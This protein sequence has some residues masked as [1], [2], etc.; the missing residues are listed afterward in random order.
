MS[1]PAGCGAILVVGGYGVVGSQVCRLLRER[2][3]AAQ[4]LIGGRSPDKAAALAR[5]LDA[6]P[7]RID[8]CDA[9]PLASLEERP[10]LVIAAVND[11]RDALLLATVRRAVALVDI[12]RWTA[13]LHAALLRLATESVSAPVMLASGWMGGVAPLLAMAA[14]RQVWPPTSIEIDILYGAADLAGPDSVDYVDR[15]EVP[16]EVIDA[17][18]ERLVKPF[19]GGHVVAFPGAGRRRTYRLDTP[20]QATLPIVTGASTVATRIVFDSRAA[21]ATLVALKRLGVIRLLS[22]ERFTRLRRKL[23]FPQTASSQGTPTVV[24]ATVRGEGAVVRASVVDRAGQSHLTAL[25]A[26][27]AA[28]RALGLDGLAAAPAAVTFPEQHPR[29]QSALATLRQHGVEIIIEAAASQD[30]A[31]VSCLAARC[32]R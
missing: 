11:P 20:E 2:H 13:R 7:V 16:F 17:G 1:A 27:I 32:T 9:D 10:R 3:P 6:T 12:A 8:T 14:A 4:L 24:L 15:L 21:T 31:A 29:P 18:R 26:V 30:V 25:G 23:L 28:E 19:T 22:A 5:E